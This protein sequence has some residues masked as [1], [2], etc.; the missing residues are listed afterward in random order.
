[1]AAR[2]YLL[3]NAQVGKETD[4]KNALARQKAVK[5]ADLVTG[6]YDVIAVVEG[7]NYEDIIQN[8]LKKV[9]PVKGIVRTETCLVP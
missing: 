6:P 8:V 7:K 9:R 4:V 1:M 3:I 2:A 5:S